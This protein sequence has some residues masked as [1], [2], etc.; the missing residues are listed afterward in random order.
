[1]FNVKRYNNPTIKKVL[2]ILRTYIQTNKMLATKIYKLKLMFVIDKVKAK[3]I[4]K[5]RKVAKEVMKYI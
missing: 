5:L 1:M 4:I 2:L 3:K